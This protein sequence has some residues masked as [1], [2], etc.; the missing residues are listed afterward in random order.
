MYQRN[1]NHNCCKIFSDRMLL[2]KTLGAK[3]SDRPKIFLILVPSGINM[4]LKRS[5]ISPLNVGKDF[6]MYAWCIVCFSCF[7]GNRP[8]SLFVYAYIPFCGLSRPVRLS[9]CLVFSGLWLRN[10]VASSPPVITVWSM[11]KKQRS[12]KRPLPEQ[13]GNIDICMHKKGKDILLL[14]S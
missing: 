6:M 7:C 8:F 9:E 3:N 10:T 13:T 1:F 5:C 12:G 2:I 14:F 4:H 11:S